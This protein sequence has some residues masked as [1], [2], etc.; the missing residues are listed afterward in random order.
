VKRSGLRDYGYTASPV[1]YRDW[2]LVETGSPAGTVAALE[3][4]T[5]KLVWQSEY[6]QPA[7]H[8]GAPVL[9]AVEGVPCLGV[10]TLRHLVV[11]RLDAGQE[12]KTIATFDW[13]TEFANNI[14]TPTVLGSDVLISSYHTHHAICRLRITR[15]EAEK[16]W[17][18][19]F[20]SHVGSPVIH[21]GRVYL[22]GEELVCL[23]WETGKLLWKGGRFTDGGSCLVTADDR[24]IVLGSKGLLCLA[25]TAKHSPDRYQALAQHQRLL[26]SDAWPHVVLA[27]GRIYIKDRQGTLKCLAVK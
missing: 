23:D 22:C 26:G 14:L 13:E 9:M 5:G 21:A 3:K 1:V 27:G 25:D 8:S 18:Q 4:A 6:N 7:G 11:M 15:G 20:A 17:Q 10:F 24:L 2:L 16:V 19:P 12:G